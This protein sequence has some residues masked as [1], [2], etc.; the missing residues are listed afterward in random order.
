MPCM[1]FCFSYYFMWDKKDS[2]TLAKM[3]WQ[4]SQWLSPNKSEKTQKPPLNHVKKVRVVEVVVCRIRASLEMY[5]V[6][7]RLLLI[8]QPLH[9]AISSC[10]YLGLVVNATFWNFLEIVIF[11]FLHIFS[12]SFIVSFQIKVPG[13]KK[14]KNG[15]EDFKNEKQWKHVAEK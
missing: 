5:P 8:T 11:F 3:L 9:T 13:L 10:R 7:C 1:Q 14:K 12:Q 2:T 6:W 15:H 4:N